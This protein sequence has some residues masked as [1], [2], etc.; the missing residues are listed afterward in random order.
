MWAPRHE[1]VDPWDF[2]PIKRGEVLI[3]RDGLF[4]KLNNR[5]EGGWI[6]TW[7]SLNRD[8][9]LYTDYLTERF[10]AHQ[11]VAKLWVPASEGRRVVHHKDEDKLNNI[12]ENLQWMTHG[13]HSSHH[14][15]GSDNPNAKLNE[16][17]AQLIKMAEGHFHARDLAYIFN[18]Q[19]STIYNIWAGRLWS[20]IPKA[21]KNNS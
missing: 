3:R 7:G 1:S 8:G 9:Y 17:S 12:P 19:A 2:K 15:R 4:L 20:T 14:K 16:I 10:Y 5:D 21:P 11:E 6:R 13:E 18:V